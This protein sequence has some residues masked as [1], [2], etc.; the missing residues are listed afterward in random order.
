[1][2]S[3]WTT[4][5]FNLIKSTFYV[6]GTC[7]VVIGVS[8]WRFQNK[9]LYVNNLPGMKSRANKDNPQGYQSPQQVNIKYS[10]VFLDVGGEKIHGWWVP[11]SSSGGPFPVILHFHGNAGNIGFRINLIRT[12]Y[13]NVPAHVFML[14]YRGYGDSQGSPSERALQQDALAAVDYCVSRAQGAPIIIYG[15]SLGGAVAIYAAVT[16]K[17][18][19][20][21]G[22]LILQNTFTSIPDMVDQLFR[23][24]RHLKRLVLN[25]FWPSDQLLSQVSCPVLFFSS[26]EDEIVPQHMHKALWRLVPQHLQYQWVE[27]HANHNT[28]ADQHEHLFCSTMNKFV[29]D[30]HEQHDS[31]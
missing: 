29:R 7:V 4:Q 31:K 6:A 26:I 3:G 25:N 8:L 19:K 11:S 24:V 27:C 16:S 2:S 22:G 14:D 9:I 21:L 23:P 15:E 20:S 17:H 12:L 18:T 5:F 10:D 28:L 30:V 1:M 13:H